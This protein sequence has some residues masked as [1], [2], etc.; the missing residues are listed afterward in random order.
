MIGETLKL[1]IGKMIPGKK[2]IDNL[3]PLASSA[4]LVAFVS[5]DASVSQDGFAF[6]GSFVPLDSFV[7]LG[8]ALLLSPVSHA[9]NAHCC[10][11]FEK[12]LSGFFFLPNLLKTHHF[13]LHDDVHFHPVIIHPLRYNVYNPYL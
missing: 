6:L 8:N 1:K 11:V 7:P 9:V 3:L 5:L 13:K 10:K 2:M 4:L 12:K